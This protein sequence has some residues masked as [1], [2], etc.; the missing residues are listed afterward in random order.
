M[1]L[2]A[3]AAATSSFMQ[4]LQHADAPVAVLPDTVLLVAHHMSRHGARVVLPRAAFPFVAAAA[5]VAAAS[6]RMT[7]GPI[8][9]SMEE[10]L[11]IVEE[12]LNE[13]AALCDSGLPDPDMYAC[14]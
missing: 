9:A 7:I 3:A 12:S 13:R 4:N 11:H 2:A 1:A 5:D 6:T 10:A 14:L 8:D